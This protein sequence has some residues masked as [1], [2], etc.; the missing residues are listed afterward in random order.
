MRHG[1]R[2]RLHESFP[3]HYGTTCCHDRNSRGLTPARDHDP[4]SGSRDPLL[5][6]DLE[7]DL[8]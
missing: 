4:G 6:W 1:D 3:F 5:G 8:A 7:H 2:V